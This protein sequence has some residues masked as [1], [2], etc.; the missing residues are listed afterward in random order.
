[1]YEITLIPGDGIGPEVSTAVT[2]VIAATGLA[3]N[4]EVVD[5]GEKAIK[6][7]GKPLPE[8]T[9]NSIRKNKVALK[10]PVTTPVG[11]GFRS[12][13][14]ALRKE[15]G[16]YANLR[17]VKSMPGINTRYENVDLLVVRENTEDL[18][19]GIEHKIGDFAA[20]AIKLI[21]RE[22]SERI[23]IFAFSQAKLLGRKKVTAV[24]KAN[25]LKFS[26]GLFLESVRKAGL[27]F[28]EI[29]YEDLIIDNLCMQLV[30]R[31]EKFDVLVL[32]NLYGD[33]VSDL[34][35][36]LVGGLGL[37]A[38][39]NLGDNAAVFEAV[40]GSAPDI[41]GKNIA[42]P[43][44]LLNSAIMMLRHINEKTAAEMIEKAIKALLSQPDKLTP[45]LG[46][47]G[48]TTSVTDFLCAYIKSIK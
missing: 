40:H 35:A 44:A 8:N 24:H 7:M 4:W 29:A 19:A 17:P 23:G 14:V 10:G 46:G 43:L 28:P 30:Q 31:P 3:I 37:V 39:A 38:G 34:C 20:E 33:I 16:L 5:A 2:K 27:Q 6:L 13:N 9:I 15:L 21:T 47:Q 25:I 11:K 32:P 45:D 22:A 18:Y 26:D 48:T 36:G 1:M 41:A 42:N 12:V